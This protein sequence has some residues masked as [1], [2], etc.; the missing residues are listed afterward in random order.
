MPSLGMMSAIESIV[1]VGAAKR[2]AGARARMR[3]RVL[4]KIIVEDMRL[5]GGEDGK[6]GSTVTPN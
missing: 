3:D 4:V 1:F 5:F 2:V 6:L